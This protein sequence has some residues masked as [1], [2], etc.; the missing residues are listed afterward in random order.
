MN[1]QQKARTSSSLKR[2][3]FS[4]IIFL[5]IIETILIPITFSKIND[6]KLFSKDAQN[7]TIIFIDA[8][9]AYDYGW[10]VGKLLGSTY[11][12]LNIAA[13]I[14][15]KDSKEDFKNQIDAIEHYCPFFYEELRGLSASLNIKLDKILTLQKFLNCILGEECTTTLSTGPAT[16]NNETFLTQNFDSNSKEHGIKNRI[17]IMETRTLTFKC[18]V[19]KINTMNYKY[20]FWGIPIVFEI[21]F[22]NEMGLGWGANGMKIT[23]NKSRYI[24][25]GPG[26]STYMLERLTMMTCKN[27]SEVAALWKNTERSS[28]TDRSW[29]HMWDN[30][31]SVWCDKEGGIL[32]IE[33]THNHIITVF[34]NSTDITGAPEGILWHANH[35]Q[36]LDPNGTGSVYPSEF[37]SS[38]MRA[39]RSLELLETNY[40][41]ITLDTCMKM[42]RDHGGGTNPDGKDSSDICRH[43]DKNLSSITVFS[44]IIEPK[45]LT[46]YWTH[47]SPCRSR[48][49]KYDFTKIFEEN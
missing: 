42:T 25:E 36:W 44:W 46:V 40:G 43:P 12:R 10:K 26:M 20:A 5:L 24:D 16:K 22:L 35:H 3:T 38:D 8:T 18:W 31:I 11:K 48:F 33:Q 39:R 4:G 7:S 27:V 9:S 32:M 23:E 49:V 30:S 14:T 6:V 41:N 19:V 34:G 15:E 17:I 45:N 37:P 28:G 1:I 2:I 47:G 29:P 13:T 21:P